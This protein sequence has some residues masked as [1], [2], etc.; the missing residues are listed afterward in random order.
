MAERGRVRILEGRSEGPETA[1]PRRASLWRNLL[2][3]INLRCYW[4]SCSD[5]TL[6]A[7]MA[8]ENPGVDRGAPPQDGAGR[9]GRGKGMNCNAA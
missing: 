8:R 9:R 1:A 5:G 7:G 4:Q 6:L 3:A 2:Q